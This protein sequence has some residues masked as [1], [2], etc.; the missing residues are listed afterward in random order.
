M[1]RFVIY[2]QSSDGVTDVLFVPAALFCTSGQEEI[3]ATCY[4]LAERF[5]QMRTTGQT[6]PEMMLLPIYSTL[7]SDLQA[8][9][10]MGERVSTDILLS[11]L[12]LM[13]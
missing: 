12:Y 10:S 6:I 4:A 5:E 9:Q 13:P 11:G 1:T 8:S 2:R 7:P 3:E